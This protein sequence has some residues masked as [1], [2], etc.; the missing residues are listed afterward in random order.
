MFALQNKRLKHLMLILTFMIQNIKTLAFADVLKT[1]KTHYNSAQ[2]EIKLYL[3]F[4]LK[5]TQKGLCPS[6]FCLFFLI[7]WSSIL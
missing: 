3:S 4:A 6:M 2:F 1:H 5:L 7:H